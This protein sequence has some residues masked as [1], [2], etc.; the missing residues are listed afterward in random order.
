MQAILT[1]TVGGEIGG[2]GGSFEIQLVDVTTGSTLLHR[3]RGDTWPYD[4][5]RTPLTGPYEF[6]IDPSHT[7]LLSDTATT[8]NDIA[9]ATS[10]ISLASVPESVSLVI[11]SGTN[12]INPRSKGV[13]TVA[14]LTTDTFDASRVDP[15][16]V[17]FGSAGAA[18]AD[19]RGQVDDV[20]GDG[21]DDLVLHFRTQDTGIVCGDTNVSL[22]GTTFSGQPI[23]GSASIRT[24]GC[25]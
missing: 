17:R 20:N 12:T 1:I 8:D 7:Y 19:G 13:I 24:V 22:T 14:I 23:E 6:T 5:L 2:S 9:A 18:E 16:S 21:R 10:T 3:G 25:K 4:Q 15:S 11:K